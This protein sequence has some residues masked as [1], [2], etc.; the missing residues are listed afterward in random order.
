MH[1]C[2]G[3]YFSDSEFGSFMRGMRNSLHTVQWQLE[4]SGDL[5]EK[6]NLERDL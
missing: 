6:Y 4:I 2:F 1:I 3:F 5:K